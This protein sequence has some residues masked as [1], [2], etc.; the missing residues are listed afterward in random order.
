M[1][2]DEDNNLIRGKRAAILNR[3]SSNEFQEKNGGAEKQLMLV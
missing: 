2:N 3:H 1:K